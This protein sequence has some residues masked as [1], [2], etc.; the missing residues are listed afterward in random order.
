MIYLCFSIQD[1]QHQ[2]QNHLSTKADVITDSWFPTSRIPPSCPANLLSSSS[3]L[4]KGYFKPP[5]L[6]PVLRA[7]HLPFLSLYSPKNDLTS[8]FTKNKATMPSTSC[9]PP[10]SLFL[11][12][13]LLPQSRHALLLGIPPNPDFPGNGSTQLTRSHI[14]FSSLPAPFHQHF[15]V[16]DSIIHMKSKKDITGDESQIV[17][18]GM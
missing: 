17:T 9:S 13:F 4:L 6:Y 12:S 5:L 10:N 18:V 8:Y 15:N 2:G 16:Q 14:K 1:I 11:V 7:H 3:S